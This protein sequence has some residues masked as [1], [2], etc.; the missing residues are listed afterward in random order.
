MRRHVRSRCCLRLG[1]VVWL[2]ATLVV[3]GL[4]AQPGVSYAS[5]AAER[6][7]DDTVTYVVKPGDM[8][9]DIAARYGTTMG[10]IVRANGLGNPDMIYPG[11]KLIIPVP[12]GTADSNVSGDAST[13]TPTATPTPDRLSTGS[14]GTDGP[15]AGIIHTVALGDTLASI[16]ATYGVGALDIAQAND[17]SDPDLIWVGQR[18][19]IPSASQPGSP[20]AL[21]VPSQTPVLAMTSAVTATLAPQPPQA[22]VTTTVSATP[23]PQPTSAPALVKPAVYVVQPGDNLGKI[24][25]RLGTTIA[26]LVAVND[27]PNSDI[28]GIGQQLIIPRPG[29]PAITSAALRPS[30]FVVSISKQRCWLYQGDTVIAKWVCS[31]GRPGTAT[32]PGSYKIQS[33]MRKAFGSTWNIW[34]P[35]W[36]GIYWAG[37]SENGIHG[38][39][40]SA[41][42]GAQ[43]WTGYVGTPITFGCVMLDN[44]NAKMLYDVAY[45]GMPV[46][47]QP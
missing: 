32:R 27:L 3:A 10:A 22:P 9:R 16:G 28:L 11:Q 13:S 14:A 38:L 40:W 19:L 24:A 30:K 45:I 37:A 26:A 5:V 17:I 31:T 6:A 8:L 25:A 35:Y 44:V 12:G 1:L 33:K 15:T 36:L 41:D 47:I 21:P 20:T 46:I 39:P 42:S 34:M 23:A 4:A 7:Q 43:V 29:D 2:L 18:L